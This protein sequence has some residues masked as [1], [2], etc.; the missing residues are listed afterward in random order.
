MRS[1]SWKG[2]WGGAPFPSFHLSKNPTTTLRGQ[3]VLFFSPGTIGQGQLC[4]SSCSPFAT[5][6]LQ[7]QSKRTPSQAEK[8]GS[9]QVLFNLGLSFSLSPASVSATAVGWGG[10]ST[11]SAVNCK[12]QILCQPFPCCSEATRQSHSWQGSS[13]RPQRQAER[14]GPLGIRSRNP[15]S[16]QPPTT[17]KQKGWH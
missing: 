12:K 14:G 10:S 11:L 6:S 2:F 4:A 13:K 9:L 3:R 1:T 8:E 15:P 5:F 16:R 17:K 7:C